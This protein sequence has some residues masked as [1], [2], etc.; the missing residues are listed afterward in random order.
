[1]TRHN[2]IGKLCLAAAVTILLLV[3][4]FA[5]VFAVESPDFDRKCSITFTMAYDGKP[6]SGG[7]L[8]LYRIAYFVRMDYSYG[9]E[10]VPEL[11]DCGLSFSQA[12]TEEFA[13]RIFM[14]V[15]SRSLP[16]VQKLIGKDGTVTFGNLEA[17]L[18]VVYQTEPANGFE[19][20]NAFCVS[21]PMPY[22]N[23]GDYLYD[24][25]ASPKPRP[26]KPDPTAPTEST[27]PTGGFPTTPS[28]EP[29]DPHTPPTNPPEYT[30][31]PSDMTTSTTTNTTTMHEPDSPPIISMEDKLP[32]TG[33]LW[34]PTWMLGI[35]GVLLLG[36][37]VLM[38]LLLRQSAEEDTQ[39]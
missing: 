34:W 38:R 32:Q 8:K 23:D 37:G 35:F 28:T 39:L 4:M 2:R 30:T 24:I 1:M 9:Y 31:L 5:C 10:W 21:L 7:S 25:Q 29:T 13:R 18:Y 20:I 26:I 16:A 19:P 12:G 6:L 11:A 33:Q 36:L 15:E 22:G 14:L 3:N 17:G 27:P